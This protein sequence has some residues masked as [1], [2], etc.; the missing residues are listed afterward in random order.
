MFCKKCGT[1]LMAGVSV[2]HACGANVNADGSVKVI[3]STP[4]ANA[5]PSPVYNEKINYEKKESKTSVGFILVILVI[6][7]LIA[8]ITIKV[9]G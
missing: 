8:I 7:A 5:T 1:K 9:L 2:C 6:L 3:S 4:V